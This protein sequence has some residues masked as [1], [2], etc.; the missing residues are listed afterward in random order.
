MALIALLG[1]FLLVTCTTDPVDVEIEE[2]PTDRISANTGP[3]I[4]VFGRYFGRCLGRDCVEIYKFD[5]QKLL[6]DISDKRPNM[7]NFYKGEF[8]HEVNLDTRLN[9]FKLLEVLPYDELNSGR[10]NIIGLPGNHDQG[11][12]YLEYQDVFVRKF[13]IIDSDKS[14]IPKSLHAYSD[15]LGEMI[16]IIQEEDTTY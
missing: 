6:E 8:K 9:L 4:V 10:S 16:D 2:N 14:N 12:Y 13:W 3:A 15:L 7:S 5:G 1:M 11:V